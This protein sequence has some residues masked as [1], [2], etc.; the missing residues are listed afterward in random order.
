MVG[1][2]T[3]AGIFTRWRVQHTQGRR[4]CDNR[5][6]GWSDAATAQGTPRIAESR[7]K[8]GRV[9]EEFFFRAFTGN[10]ALLTV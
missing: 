6:R 10:V 3:V 2:N 1:L 7:Q 5:V 9:K 4:P 8:L